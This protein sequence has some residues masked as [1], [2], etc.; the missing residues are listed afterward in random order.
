MPWISALGKVCTA[1]ADSVR[2][3]GLLHEVMP[4]NCAHVHAHASLHKV[5]CAYAHSYWSELTVSF[6]LGGTYWQDS[7]PFSPFLPHYLRVVV[8]VCMC[9]ECMSDVICTMTTCLLYWQCRFLPWF[10]SV[11]YDWS[12][13]CFA[14]PSCLLPSLIPLLL[15]SSSLSPLPPSDFHT[16][17]ST[18]SATMH[19]YWTS[20]Q[21]Y[22]VRV[23]QRSATCTAAGISV[24]IVHCSS[25]A[26]VQESY[27]W[28]T[29][30]NLS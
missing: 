28:V 23:F 5:F 21:D 25:D 1:W 17:R 8:V 15:S 27:M 26:S 3:A 10:G 2:F 16:L 18:C 30:R 11:S 7:L 24:R 20:N 4:T 13:L 19:L 22:I 12:F 6:L 29:Y 14:L 9:V